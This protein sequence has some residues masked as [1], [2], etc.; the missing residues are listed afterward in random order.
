MLEEMRQ[1]AAL[2]MA[3]LYVR[4][5]SGGAGLTRAVGSL[6]GLS[7]PVLSGVYAGAL[8]NTPATPLRSASRTNTTNASSPGTS[9]RPRAAEIATV[10]TS[11]P[12]TGTSKSDPQ[13]KPHRDFHKKKTYKRL[14]FFVSG[15]SG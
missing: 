14:L 2:G 15:K 1:A 4:E 3:A 5:E 8:T 13:I 7:G 6:L 12:Q 11:V 9:N 10:R